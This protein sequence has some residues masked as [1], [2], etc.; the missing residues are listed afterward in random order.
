[1][2]RLSSAK[3]LLV[4]MLP[5]ALVASIP[6]AAYSDDY[7]HSLET[8]GISSPS[9]TPEMEP[10]ASAAD[11]T[12]EAV[13]DTESAPEESDIHPENSVNSS[14]SDNADNSS[15]NEQN[16][17]LFLDRSSLFDTAN[18]GT[19]PMAVGQDRAV[20]DDEKGKGIVV[21]T[22]TGE[23]YRILPGTWNGGKTTTMKPIP[24]IPLLKDNGEAESNRYN[25]V[26]NRNFNA[27]ASA[28][29]GSMYVT[30]NILGGTYRNKQR[31]W[32]YSPVTNRWAQLGSPQSVGSGLQ[33]QGG[34][35]DPVR[36]RYIIG[37]NKDGQY[38]LYEVS[39]GGSL[40]SRGSLSVGSTSTNGDIAIDLSGTTL[41]VGVGSNSGGAASLTQYTV[42]MDS[43]RKGAP[44]STGTKTD[45]VQTRRASF[46]PVGMSFSPSGALFVATNSAVTATNPDLLY[47]VVS[48]V[49]SDGTYPIQVMPSMVEM[50][51]GC[52]D[53]RAADPDWQNA[54]IRKLPFYNPETGNGGWSCERNVYPLGLW[55]TQITDTD[56][57]MDRS[58]LTLE[59]N[60]VD[61][62]NSG[63]SSG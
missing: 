53:T 55:N 9:A 56:G 41:V 35:Y 27:L 3:R 61:R 13:E 59:K 28:P 46:A 43:V 45:A 36:Q 48:E 16:S 63:T 44:R 22:S 32:K 30:E 21:V 52:Q 19:E 25:V 31:F 10:S 15:D 50:R 24:F 5:F 17:S 26:P 4:A 38:Y 40:T 47:G 51:N 37:A 58:L 42:P 7:T 39:D 34:A 18:R 23:L 49:R 29:D 20:T 6:Q 14:L 57:Y 1:M 2:R 62:K 33:V 11:A 54:A 12:E 8:P 60:L